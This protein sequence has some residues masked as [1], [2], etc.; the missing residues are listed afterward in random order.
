MNT[1]SKTKRIKQTDETNIHRSRLL[2]GLPVEEHRLS[3]AGISTS[4]LVGGEGSPLILLH[5]PGESSLWWLRAIPRLVTTNRVIVP[6]LPGHGESV[7]TGGVADASL[8][9]P[10]LGELIEQTC[11]SPPVL[12]GNILGGSIAARFA[13]R[14][15]EQIRR[16]VLVDS[17]G[18]GKFRPAP[19]F[20]FGLLR[21]MIHRK[22]LCPCRSACTILMNS[23][24]R[25]ANGGTP[26]WPMSWNA[27]VMMT[28]AQP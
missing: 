10:W 5:G 13:I 18:L 19:K 6:D 12:V 27:R 25:W 7:F 4:V 20:A 3:L 9:L 11:P 26:S 17:L 2:A 24:M 1:Q 14:R 16:L 23:A 21:F 15:G 8:I 22:K 28:E